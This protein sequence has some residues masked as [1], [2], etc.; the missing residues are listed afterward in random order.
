MYAVILTTTAPGVA[1]N[2]SLVAL[3]RRC[4]RWR[5]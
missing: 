5:A 4:S 1:I 2:H 3:E